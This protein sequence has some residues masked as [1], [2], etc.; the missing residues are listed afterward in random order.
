MEETP[1]DTFTPI[2]I[3][4][5]DLLKNSLTIPSLIWLGLWFSINTGPWV[6]REWPSTTIGYAHYARTVFPFVMLPFIFFLLQ[7][8]SSIPIFTG[9]LRWWFLYGLTGLFSSIVMS[10]APWHGVYWTVLYLTV[11]LSAVLYIKQGEP[12]RQAV[13]LN[14]EGW[15]ITFIFLSILLFFARDVLLVESRWGLTGY[16][17]VGRMQEVSGMPMSRSS[18]LA[19]FAAI[20]GIAA[21]VFFWQKGTLKRPVWGVIF[22]ASFM[23]IYLMQSRGAMLGFAFAVGFVMLFLGPKTRIVGGVMM[24]LAAIMLFTNVIPQETTEVV[25]Q[26]FMRGQSVEELRTLTGRTRAWEHAWIY[27]NRSPFIGWGAQADRIFIKEHVHN[28]YL[29][30]LMTSGYIGAT[31]F[32]IG[33]LQAWLLFLKIW[34]KGIDRL[35][36]QRTMLVQVGGILAFFTVRSIPEVSGALYG[37][38]TMLMIPALAYLTTLQKKCTS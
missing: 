18:G 23:L 22:L 33:L 35:C 21:F 10:P 2:N 24:L 30:A 31:F 29:Y 38:D 6:L 36:G 37:V 11:I 5:K 8:R 4:L 1:S 7:K 20:P 14:Y 34:R 19:R 27:I 32:V 16:G 9:P 17:V 26:R 3:G 15:V 25:V 12:L 28:T 13:L